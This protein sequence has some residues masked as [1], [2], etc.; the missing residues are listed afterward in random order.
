M[1]TFT[2]VIGLVQLVAA[3][4]C[5][6]GGFVYHS[7]L[8]IVL[9]ALAGCVYAFRGVTNVLDALLGASGLVLDLDR[10]LSLGEARAARKRSPAFRGARLTRPSAK[11]L[12]RGACP[13]LRMTRTR[14]K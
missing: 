12:A 13:R 4:G 1:K 3:V 8:V 11:L 2:L 6:V 14:G 10:R 7:P 9:L 5:A